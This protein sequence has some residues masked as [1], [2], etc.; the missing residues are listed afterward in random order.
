MAS[1]AGFHDR[2]LGPGRPLKA[3]LAH[4][5]PHQLLVDDD[6][7]LDLQGGPDPQHAIGAPRAGVDVGDEVGQEQMADL[8]IA[9]L[10][11]LDVVIGGARD[12]HDPAPDALGVAQ[13]VQCSDNLVLPFGLM[14]SISSKSRAAVLTNVSSSSRSLIRRRAWARRSA[15]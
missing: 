9:G 8:A 11:E 7:L 5:L 14:A 3:Q 13:V 10:M 1:L 6:A 15:S 4:D 12:A 2:F